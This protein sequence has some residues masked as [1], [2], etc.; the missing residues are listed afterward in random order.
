MAS[1]N[2]N[3]LI[4]DPSYP[5]TFKDSRNAHALYVSDDMRLAP[6][7]KFLYYAV[8][9]INPN[10]VSVDFEQRH[11]TELNYLVK[12]MDLP[13]YT[14][15]ATTLNQYNRK[16]NIYTKIAYDPVN[17]VFHDDNVGVTNALWAYYYGYYFSDRN[18]GTESDVLP[19]AYVRNT[20]DAKNSFRY[21][22][23]NN[24]S[25][26]FFQSIKLYVLT[27]GT[28]FGY[29]LCNPKITSWQHDTMDQ[30]QGNGI[31]ENKMTIA[32][33]AV[34]YYQ[35]KI[36][37]GNNPSGFA[38]DHY[39]EDFGPLILG[40]NN[41][42]NN[43]KV[44]SFLNNSI[45]NPDLTNSNNVNA[46]LTSVNNLTGNQQNA[47]DNARNLSQIANQSKPNIGGLTDILINKDSTAT[48]QITTASPANTVKAID[49]RSVSTT[50]NRSIIGEHVGN[51]PEIKD[52]F[53]KDVTQA[54]Q[55]SKN[56]VAFK[57][58]SN[59]FN[60]SNRGSLDTSI[61]SFD[62]TTADQGGR[63][64]STKGY[65]YQN[66]IVEEVQY[67]DNTSELLNNNPVADIPSNPF[68]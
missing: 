12:Q 30:T 43:A 7:V 10:V 3:S 35:G 39:D 25:E 19:P 68:A 32:Y 4:R 2:S 54:T 58:E 33:D 21:G 51:N 38:K 65:R 59:Q 66:S 45:A 20:Y 64:E 29:T 11:K 61:G 28:Y 41:S 17:L 36:S 14:T 5:Y 42:P 53:S 37:K 26:P 24:S 52:A 9:N 46:A 27:K 15:E 56:A 67:V 60:K 22:L 49:Q 48:T 18:N 31:V 50:R 55:K 40:A 8:F 57:K 62:W 34:I 6:K 44:D 63:S 47:T 16:T 1:T 13:R 23:D